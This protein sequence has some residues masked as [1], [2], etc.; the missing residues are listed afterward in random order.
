MAKDIPKDQHWDIGHYLLTRPG[1]KGGRAV[2]FYG[3]L[4]VYFNMYKLQQLHVGLLKGQEK[5]TRV[6]KGVLLPLL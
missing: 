2:Y 1:V 4:K 3:I 5:K 6:G